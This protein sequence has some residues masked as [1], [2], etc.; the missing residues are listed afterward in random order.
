MQCLFSR[1]C[2][3]CYVTLHLLLNHYYPS[4]I[5]L[6]LEISSNLAVDPSLCSFHYHSIISTPCRFKLLL[7]NIIN[8]DIQ[9]QQYTD[10]RGRSV[11][12]SPPS[13]SFLL[14]FAHIKLVMPS[15]LYRKHKKETWKLCGSTRSFQPHQQ[16]IDLSIFLH[17]NVSC[18]KKCN[19]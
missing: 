6:R 15:E 13:Y 18:S 14:L 2:D 11:P 19:K 7:K 5:H 1:F 9:L 4:H 16:S 17:V 3:T 12:P 10:E 8:A